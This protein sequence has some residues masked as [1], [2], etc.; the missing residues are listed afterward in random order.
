MRHDGLSDR[1]LTALA[2]SG[3][4]MTVRLIADAI[5]LDQFSTDHRARVMGTVQKLKQ[6]GKVAVCSGKSAVYSIAG[7][8]LLPPSSDGFHGNSH[9]GDMI[10]CMCCRRKF[11]TRDKKRNR[12]C[13]SCNGR[14]VSPYAI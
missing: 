13:S 2:T 4:W 11:K 14:S 12:L 1:I 10:D 3:K 8:N 6:A 7:L 9:K 5:G